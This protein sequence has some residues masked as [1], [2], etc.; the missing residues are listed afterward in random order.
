MIYLDYAAHT[1]VCEEVLEAFHIAAKEFIGNPNSPHTPGVLAKKR[2]EEAS[3]SIGH[4]LHAKASEIIYTS[5]ASESNNLAIKGVA[6]SY[7]RYGKHIITSFLEHASVTGTAAALKNEGFEVDFVNVTKDGSIDLEHL[8][9][10]LREDTILVSTALVDSEI[11]AIQPIERIYELV[12][13]VPHCFFHVDATQAVGKIPVTFDNIDL[14]TISGHKIYGLTGC[15]AL[16]KK[17]HIMLE[18]L[19]HG[20][21]STTSFRSGTPALALCVSLESAVKFTTDHLSEFYE[22]VK[23]KNLLIRRTLE[24]N[25]NVVIHTPS[26]GSPYILNL[27]LKGV[28][29]NAL[30][31]A[32]D[33]RG[34]CVATK[35]ACCAVNTVS[36]PV[37]AM[38]KDKKLSLATLR[39]SL[40]HLTTTEEIESFLEIF[41]DVILQNA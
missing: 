12:K 15:G 34:I 10:L 17:E 38:T 40:S 32:L 29:T 2:L 21:I 33:E 16:L 27:S 28:N 22:Q 20:G 26:E 23:E 37:Y 5:G 25:K 3:E 6:K 41:Q 36:K 31:A 4:I 30:Q 7:Q 19:I 18:P 8:K 1:P 35:S 11:G 14:M 9:E 39:I 24:K 13:A